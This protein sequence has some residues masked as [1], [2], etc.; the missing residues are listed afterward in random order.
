MEVSAIYIIAIFLIFFASFF[1]KG[2]VGFGDPL[3]SG[4]LLSMFLE[5]RLISPANLLISVPINAY[6]AWINRKSFSV[7]S[8]I[9]I[10]I[11]MLIGVVPGTLLLKYATSWI[12]KG[13]LGFVVI[14]IGVEMLI[15]KKDV[16]TKSSYAV[17]A[18]V[19]FLSGVTAGLYGI[20][21]FFIAYVE[22][23]SSNRNEFRGNLCF[24]F[25]IENICRTITYF[26]CGIMTFD[27]YLLALLAVPGVIAGLYIG[28]KI[29]SRM[30]EET[31]RL[32]TVVIFI[33]GGVSIV[34]K[35]MP[36]PLLL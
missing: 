8:T 22:R 29:D 2:I 32:I 18:L 36:W 27:I 3:L 9:P 12:L 1:I 35:T 21:M 11:W 34:L 24:V 15:R 10:L 28:G 17:M 31:V 20:N 5:N 14:L 33:A 26:A 16:Q 6:M 25:L 30:R 13:G 7:K 23:T 4:P 19:S